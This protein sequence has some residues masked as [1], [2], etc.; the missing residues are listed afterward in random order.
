MASDRYSL[1]LAGGHSRR[2]G[3]DK[4]LLPWA[5]VTLLQH[6]CASARTVSAE[7]VLVAPRDRPYE[8]SGADRWL[9]DSQSQGPLAAIAQGLTTVPETAWVLVLA[10]DLPHLEPGV[11]QAW[12]QHLPYLSPA[13]AAY[14]PRRQPLCG[15]Y[16]ASQRA[17]LDRFLATGRRACQDWLREI[18]RAIAPCPPAMLTNLNTPA[19]WHALAA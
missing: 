8:T 18:P 11:L 19:D 9:D 6:V 15:W 2:L 5:G 17:A 16:R 10:C 14:L 4:A 12:A 13:I 7:V 3:R 1:V